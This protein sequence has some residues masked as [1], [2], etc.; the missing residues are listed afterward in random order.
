MED[1]RWEIKMEGN[2]VCHNS[3]LAR[4]LIPSATYICLA[5]ILPSE[6]YVRLVYA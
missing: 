5:Q 2:G 3:K 1:G 6:Y 4:N